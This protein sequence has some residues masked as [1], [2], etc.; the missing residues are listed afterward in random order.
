MKLDRQRWRWSVACLL[1]IVAAFFLLALNESWWGRVGVFHLRPYFADTAAIL[2]AGEAQQAGRDAYLPN[3]F[4]PFGR[5]HVYGPWWLVTGKLGLTTADTWWVGAAL[6]LAT[7]IAMLVLLAPRHAADAGGVLLLLLSPP[8]LLGLERG[9]NDLMIFLL[10]AAGTAWLARSSRA[11][12]VAGSATLVLA[13]VLKFYPLAALA[14]VL[15]RRERFP[16]VAALGLGAVA[17]FAALWWVQ[18][19]G[20]FRALA[21]APR[22]DSIY[23]YG[24]RIFSLTW[25]HAGGARGW[26]LAGFALGAGAALAVLWRGRGALTRAIPDEGPHA[27]AAVAGGA[28]WLFCYLANNNYSYRAVLLLLVAPVWLA[29][30]RRTEATERALGRG[31]CL[32][33]LVT[34]WVFMPKTFAIEL[35]R[36]G[37]G[38]AVERWRWVLFVSGVEQMLILGLSVALAISLVGWAARRAAFFRS[39]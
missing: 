22:P 4:D 37:G 8:V 36:A 32:L 21:L 31:S 18:R 13:A 33:L 5:P 12:G 34:L 9:N 16:R 3:P 1:A 38:A 6:S 15:G 24:I 7:V 11:A 2:A 30:A 14:A 27:L 19:D 35:M 17:V 10:L 28:C 20:F 26:L 23:A 39:E 25:T 29:L